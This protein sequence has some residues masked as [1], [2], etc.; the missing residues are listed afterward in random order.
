M[1]SPLSFSPVSIHLFAILHLYFFLF[2]IPTSRHSLRFWH[3]P[4]NGR[5]THTPTQSS[6]LPGATLDYTRFKTSLHV[7]L[8]LPQ[9]ASSRCAFPRSTLFFPR[10]TFF[11][12]LLHSASN[13]P[14][15]LAIPSLHLLPP[16]PL[17]PSPT[18]LLTAPHLPHSQRQHTALQKKKTLSPLNPELLSP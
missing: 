10:S 18:V 9:H 5:F 7:L 11:L 4:R 12:D 17:P 15:P 6:T 1:L 16:F 13:H 8:Y 3:A 2:P 14:R